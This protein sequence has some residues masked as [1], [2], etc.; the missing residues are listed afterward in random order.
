[1]AVPQCTTGVL[2]HCAGR[3]LGS[4]AEAKINMITQPEAGAQPPP[5]EML[6]ESHQCPNLWRTGQ[7]CLL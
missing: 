7:L 4:G 5:L 2:K 1:M 6:L 3:A